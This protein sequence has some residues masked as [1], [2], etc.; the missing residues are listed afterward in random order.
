[1]RCDG[2]TVLGCIG[3]Y[4]NAGV[5]VVCWCV[6]RVWAGCCNRYVGSTVSG[7]VSRSRM[8]AAVFVLLCRCGGIVDLR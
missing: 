3:V 4:V 6:I 2:C 5:V 7:M 1:M 8:G